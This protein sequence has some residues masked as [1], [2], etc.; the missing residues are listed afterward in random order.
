M[1][2][3]AVN[4]GENFNPSLAHSTNA[5]SSNLNESNKKSIGKKYQKKFDKDSSVSKGL[6]IIIAAYLLFALVIPLFFVVGKSL[7][8]FEFLPKQI[9]I[10]MDRG[11]GFVEKQSLSDWLFKSGRKIN[12]GIRASQTSSEPLARIIPKSERQDVLRY[13]IIDLS[14]VGGQVVFKDYKS[15]QNSELIVQKEDFGQVQIRPI[16][17]YNF[18]NY[19]FYFA[20][21]NLRTSIFNSL[22]VALS[23]VFIVLPIAFAFAYGIS[24]T[25]MKFRRT[26]RLVAMIPVLAPSLLPAIGLIYMFGKQGVANWLIFNADIYGPLGVII[27]SVFFTLPHALLIM[28][29]AL[30]ASDQRLYDAAKV[31]GASNIRQFFTITLP[32]VKYGLI[33]AAFVVFTLVITD[34]GVPKVIGGSFNMLALDVYKQVV[35][36][37]N[38]QI[39]SVV[40]MVLLLP[41]LVAFV[42]DRWISKRQQAMFSS[43]AKPIVIEDNSLR[44]WSFFSFNFLV[45]FFILSIILM[46]QAAALIKFWPY[47]LE[48]GFQHY[49]FE[50]YFSGGWSAFFNSI[51]MAFSVATLASGFIFLAAYLVEKGQG[52]Q[53]LRSLVKFMGML[54]MAVPGMVLG[55]AYIFFFNNPGN[56]L[57]LIYG[58]MI[59]LIVNT[60]VHFYTVTYLTATTALKQLDKEFEAVTRSLRQPFWVTFFRISLPMSL[61]A[62]AEIWLYIFVNAM[63]TVSAVVF[64]YSPDTVLAS[65]AVLNMDDAGDTA[66]AAAMALMIFYTNVVFRILM[67]GFTAL[68]VRKQRWRLNQASDDR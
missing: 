48:L 57:H 35:G 61:P 20:N 46:C 68:I 8:T 30:S 40:S 3:Q 49:Q 39:G 21:K 44:D 26:F 9:I 28:L 56:P 14:S 50:R 12:D 11:A 41:A 10:E 23:V 1:T 16:M 54:P 33:S 38:F 58:T 24:R 4:F 25:K 36:Q 42:V 45:G 66:P 55:L 5:S 52:S 67:S 47:N 13:K 6:L 29:V 32:G 59:I 37:Q 34:F 43:S 18:S 7:Q 31:L 64:L 51:E 65:V 60:S 62:L 22:W 17:Q 15:V 2:E 19:S 27:A 53:A 63:T